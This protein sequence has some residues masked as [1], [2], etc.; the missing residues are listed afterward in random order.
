MSASREYWSRCISGENRLL[1]RTVKRGDVVASWAAFDASINK[2]REWMP[3]LRAV[4]VL[5][6]ERR[7]G[8][9]TVVAAAV[10][11]GERV[12]VRA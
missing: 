10:V 1:R 3:G 2:W 4:A 9:L 11:G 8:T 6:E 7:N 12:E 5:E